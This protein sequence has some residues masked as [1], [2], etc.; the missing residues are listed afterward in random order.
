MT[1]RTF[2]LNDRLRTSRNYKILYNT[3]IFW[4]DLERQLNNAE[5]Y[6]LII[7]SKESVDDHW[8]IK[9]HMRLGGFASNRILEV[10]YD[11]TKIAEKTYQCAKSF[12]KNIAQRNSWEFINLT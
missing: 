5:L 10:V 1:G 8:F 9:A 6:A 7:P 3:K 12:A 2:L 11:E 4:P